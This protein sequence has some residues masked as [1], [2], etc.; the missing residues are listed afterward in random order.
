MGGGGIPGGRSDAHGTGPGDVGSR[1]LR[2]LTFL[3]RIVRAAAGAEDQAALLHSI[4]RETNEAT[5]TQVC[6]LYLW[7]EAEQ[8]LVLTATNGLSDWAVGSLKLRLGE[9]ITGWVAAHRQALAVEDVRLDRRFSWVQNLDEDRFISM[10]SVPIVHPGRMLG[11]LNVQTDTRRLFT[12]GEMAFFEALAAQLAGIIEIT[13]LR[14]E[15]ALAQELKHQALHDGLT[16]LPNRT[17]LDD[18]LTQALHSAARTRTSGA[19]LL[20][21]L[22]RF[23]EVNDGLG[24][25]AGDQLL[26]QIGPRLQQVLRQSDTVARLGGDEFVVL[27]PDVRLADA[28]ALAAKLLD[29]LDS[30][31]TIGE[32]AIRVGASA[33]VVVF[34]EDGAEVATLMR[35]ADIAMYR[36]KRD[37]GGWAL[38]TGE[39]DHGSDRLLLTAALHQ[40]VV[41]RGLEL[42]FQPKVFISDGHL[43]GVEALARWTHPT[44]GPIP[45]AL[46]IPLAEQTGTIA[47]LSYW[48]LEEAIRQASEWRREGQAIVVAVNLS[49][50]S[51]RDLQ[52]PTRLEGFLARLDVPPGA[53][54]LEITE[55]TIMAEPNQTMAVLAAI[56]AMGIKLSVDDFG[57]GYSSLA[58][59][60]RL[61]V[62]ELKIDKSFVL[63]M[64]VAPSNA[65]IVRSTIDL[66]HNLGLQVVAEG[67]ERT[68]VLSQLSSLGC[69][70]AQGFLLGQPMPAA[71]LSSWLHA[72]AR[73]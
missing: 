13:G 65:L 24:H 32:H 56:H 22:D 57:T 1:R 15:L 51:L 50:R 36:A 67:V 46:F 66:A 26:K 39:E 16:D 21:D 23:K 12:A 30:P 43:D 7:D 61:P 10:L 49:M 68:E 9:G 35:R 5:A 70:V 59:L 3:E 6:S 53:L 33:G 69:D 62:D 25:P 34:P 60:A 58:H 8:R 47:S 20:L 71:A 40:A 72:R 63:D 29:A 37:G 2:E 14:R 17:L 44:R 4:V 19:L 11:V 73:A 64:D 31:F 55:S 48:V 27:M 42:H 28:A 45:P 18:R 52:L 54:K 38:Y 41:Q